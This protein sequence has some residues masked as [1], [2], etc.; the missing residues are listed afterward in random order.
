MQ[1]QAEW[2]S[3]KAGSIQNTNAVMR[4]EFQVHACEPMGMWGKMKTDLSCGDRSSG[5]TSLPG[6]SAIENTCP[7][8]GDHLK[9]CLGNRLPLKFDKDISWDLGKFSFLSGP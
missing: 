3:P 2:N 4:L 1:G 6:V 8:D 7:E 9:R 5:L